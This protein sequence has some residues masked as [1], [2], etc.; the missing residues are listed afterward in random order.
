MVTND[1]VPLEWTTDISR[2][3]FDSLVRFLDAVGFGEVSDYDVFRDIPDYVGKSFGPCASAII[4]FE[5]GELVAMARVFSDECLCSWLAEICVHP[6]LQRRGV[7]RQLMTRVN[8]RFAHTPLYLQSFPSQ[9]EFFEKCG[10]PPKP[11]LVACAGTS[12][13][14][15]P[16]TEPPQG[17]Q[18]VDGLPGVGWEQVS[19]LYNAVGFEADASSVGGCFGAGV[20]A[21][22]ALAEGQLVGLA[23]VMT[24]FLE[25]A[26]LAEVCVHPDW[27]RQGIGR[28][29]ISSVRRQVS[30]SAF[31]AD[32][33]TTQ[34]E[35][36]TKCGVTPRPMLVAC[37]RSPIA[38]AGARHVDS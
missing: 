10:V 4:A 12:R 2:L 20:V 36:F 30:K 16:E 37:S 34:T 19:G 5:E 22:F 31:Y 17:I 26:W 15:P 28:A 24:N 6:R 11:K 21:A 38:L 33:F 13:S 29:L 8:E 7:G 3:D 35:F 32:A 14:V 9:T 27:Q 25:V 23:R 18:I 1:S